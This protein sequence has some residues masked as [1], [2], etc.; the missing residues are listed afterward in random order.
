MAISADKTLRNG[1]D[2]PAFV[3]GDCPTLFREA[4][5]C[6]RV[7]VFCQSLKL[8]EIKV[9]FIADVFPRDNMGGCFHGLERLERLEIASRYADSNRPPTLGEKSFRFIT[10]DAQAV[11]ASR[12][13]TH[14]FRA[15]GWIVE[16]WIRYCGL[17]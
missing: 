16:K 15:I 3:F 13:A 6:Q 17:V 10:N 2:V 9:T 14:L 8:N 7:C 11:N 5:S 12:F 1:D 4:D